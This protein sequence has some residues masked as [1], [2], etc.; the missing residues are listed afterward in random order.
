MSSKSAVIIASDSSG[1]QN[2]N[3]GTPG[4]SSTPRNPPTLAPKPTP[5]R[6]DLST[7]GRTLDLSE[8][9]DSTA[10]ELSSSRQS[11]FGRQD[12]FDLEDGELDLIGPNSPHSAASAQDI[13]EAIA[14]NTMRVTEF[15]SDLADRVKSLETSV[16]K[17]A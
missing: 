2:L 15:I 9:M 16:N 3:L 7:H 14:E 1:I 17:S 13:V 12:A 6:R 5:Q 4:E 8:Q 11:T 10:P